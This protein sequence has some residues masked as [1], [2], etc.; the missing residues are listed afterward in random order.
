MKKYYC[1]TCKKFKNRMQLKKVDDTRVAFYE[2]R[3]CHSHNIYTTEDVINK[4]I[5]H[6][7]AP[8]DLNN[9]HGSFI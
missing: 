3:Y 6:T 4:L 1:P 9:R 5:S 8:K 2:C 7:L